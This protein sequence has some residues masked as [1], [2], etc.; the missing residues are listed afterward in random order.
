MHVLQQLTPVCTARLA[1]LLCYSFCPASQLAGEVH[2]C[3]AAKAHMIRDYRRYDGSSYGVQ[4]EESLLKEK[5]ELLRE[6]LARLQRER[7]AHV[8]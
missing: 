2:S 8:G 3:L 7:R 1:N 4:H 5:A 6:E